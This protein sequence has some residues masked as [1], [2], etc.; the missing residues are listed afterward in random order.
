MSSLQCCHSTHIFWTYSIPRFLEK[1]LSLCCFLLRSLFV[2]SMHWCIMCR[3]HTCVEVRGQRVLRASLIGPELTKL[4]SW[5]VSESQRSTCPYIQHWDYKSVPPL[6]ASQTVCLCIV[7]TVP[8]CAGLCAGCMHMCRL[9]PI[10]SVSLY[11]PPAWL[12]GKLLGLPVFSFAHQGYS[13]AQCS[14]AF[15]GSELQSSCRAASSLPTELAS[16]CLFSWGLWGLDWRV[17]RH[18]SFAGGSLSSAPWVLHLATSFL[19]VSHVYSLPL[20][21]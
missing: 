4:E 19:L 10:Q 11:S 3:R 15:L 16:A 5:L 7:F 20:A 17:C 8:V 1:R 13:R 14:C 6:G 21:L 2:Q 12:A 9:R 18:K